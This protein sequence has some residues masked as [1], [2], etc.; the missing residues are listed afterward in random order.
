MKDNLAKAVDHGRK[1]GADYVEVRGQRLFKTFLTTKD[2]R[3]EA[4]KEGTESGA[5]VR[6]LAKGAWGFVSL[7]K[8]DLKL[9]REAVG[10]AFK[11]AKAAGSK[12]KTPV[13]LVETKAVEDRVV[14]NPKKDPREVPIEEKI[15]VALTMDKTIFNYDRRIK[16]CTIDYLDV[17]GTNYFINSDGTYIEQDKLYVWSRILS[18]AREA[19]VFTSGREE[20]G[21]TAGFEV[22]DIETP[23]N[24]GTI[25]AKRIIDQLKAKAPKGGTFPAVIGTNVVGV[26]IHEALGHLA[27]A[28]LTLSGS[29]LS[30]KLEKKIASEVITVYDDGTVKGAFGS[31][32]Y[33]D[34]GV[35]T[36]KTILIKN[37]KLAGLM[38]NRETAYKFN[39]K[40][41]GNA[42]AE[43]FRFEPII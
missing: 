18:S 22:F 1:L 28:D 42:R 7:G 24:V 23:E 15:D 20:I 16:S 38:H 34:E 29:V 40:P 9:L 26:F 35:P 37:G 31:F 11:L 3:V 14:A 21:S 17:T 39:M 36:Q 41:T 5:G 32:K 10:E 4:A 33:D 13:K 8:L 43:D 6:V 19:N 12:V 2:G 25:I 30:D 27:E